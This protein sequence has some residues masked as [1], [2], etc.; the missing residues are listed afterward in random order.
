MASGFGYRVYVV[1]EG[2]GF[3]EKDLGKIFDLELTSGQL[4]N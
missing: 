4:E 2:M 3:G 1:A